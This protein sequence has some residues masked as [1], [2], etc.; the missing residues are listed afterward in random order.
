MPANS[1]LLPL[2]ARACLGRR[3]L[4]GE[5]RVLSVPVVPVPLPH[6]PRPV[7]SVSSSPLSLLPSTS[8]HQA[9]K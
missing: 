5:P 2:L 1:S 4:E 7:L 9:W 6:S 8:S 3:P